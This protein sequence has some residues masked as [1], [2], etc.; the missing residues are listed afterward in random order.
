VPMTMMVRTVLLE[1]SPETEPLALL[2]AVRGFRRSRANEATGMVVVQERQRRGA[3]TGGV[4]TALWPAW[5]WR[6]L[7]RVW[8]GEPLALSHALCHRRRRRS[9]SRVVIHTTNRAS[10]IQKSHL[11]TK[12]KPKTT[13]TTMMNRI[14]SQF[15]CRPFQLDRRYP[16]YKWGKPLVD[17]APTQHASSAVIPPS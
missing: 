8:N 16:D 2:L 1:G 15:I 7:P 3:D 9:T 4:T 6:R 14:S 10:A 13:I 17:E 11:T 5:W 12:P